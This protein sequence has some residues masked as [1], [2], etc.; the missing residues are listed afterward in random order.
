MH[1]FS[2][3]AAGH[4]STV[5]AHASTTVDH[6]TNADGH[7]GAVASS[8]ELAPC[9]DAC[10]T[11]STGGHSGMLSACILALLAGL[12]L[13]LRPLLVH[14]LSPP[15]RVLMSRLRPAVDVTLSRAPSLTFLSISRT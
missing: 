10:M 1:T 8:A 9:E 15:L 14:R 11:G 4:G 12:L 2:S 13:L 6:A 5:G 3:E 7:S